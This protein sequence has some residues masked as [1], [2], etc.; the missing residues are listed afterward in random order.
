MLCIHDLWS[1]MRDRLVCTPTQQQ[2]YLGKMF[3]VWSYFVVSFDET[4]FVVSF[5]CPPL[6]AWSAGVEH[7]FKLDSRRRVSHDV[8]RHSNCLTRRHPV[9]FLLVCYAVWLVWKGGGGTMFLISMHL[10]IFISDTICQI[11]TASKHTYFWILKVK[12]GLT[13]NFQVHRS[14]DTW[15]FCIDCST[16]IISSWQ[17]WHF[18]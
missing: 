15:A 8:T 2:S 12:V 17:F 18:L 1:L 10:D 4:E 6:L 9:H 3:D 7:P 13:F 5:D 14:T 16:R 11:F